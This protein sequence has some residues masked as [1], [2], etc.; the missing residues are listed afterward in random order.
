MDML[1]KILAASRERVA[2]A[3]AAR[4]T[5]DLAARCASL[6]PLGFEFENALRAPGVSFICEVKK[7]SPSKGLIS[8]AFPYLDIAADYEAAGAACVSVLTEPRFFL[9]SDDVLAEIA[10]S[11]SLPVLRKDFIVDPWQI[12]EARLMGAGAVLL[13]CAALGGD[14]LASFIGVADGLGMTAL[15]EAHNPAELAAALAA[16]ARVIGAN[17]RDLRTFEVDLAN[18][19]RLKAMAPPGILFVAESGVRAR[20]DVELLEGAGVD[21]VLVGEALM[22]SADRRAALGALMG[23]PT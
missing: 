1:E 14:E 16:G 11:I 18:S 21:A 5:D 13:I 23:R 19:V 20:A 4:A 10:A 22:R 15:A 9:G 17:N 3:K 6:P 8:P 2:A 7:A 12:Y